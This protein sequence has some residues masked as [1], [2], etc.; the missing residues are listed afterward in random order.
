MSS[1]SSEIATNT[2][3]PRQKR[4]KLNRA[5]GSH[6]NLGGP[7]RVILI[8]FG[9]F[10]LSQILLAPLIVGL[11]H[12][13]LNPNTTLDIEKNIP[14]QALFILVAEASA[15]WLAI[16]AVRHRG[17]SL[18]AIGLGRRPQVTDLWRAAVGFGVFYFFLIIAGLFINAFWPTL[19]DQQQDIGFNNITNE[20]QNILAFISLVLIPPVG[21][22]ILVRGYLYSGLRMVWRFWPALLVTSLLFGAAHL[23]FGSS[24]A[25]VWGAAVDTFILSIV[26]VFLRERSG[27]LYAGML[28]HMLNNLIAF[29]VHFK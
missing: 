4:W 17:L 28:V 19:T 3:G 13:I 9:I 7:A 22:E 10:F 29:G 2:D 11:I 16:T 5:N 8:T 1:V 23:E 18:A 12:T 25:L 15:A 21:E 24:S 26:L 27:A 6:K 14:Q 20:T